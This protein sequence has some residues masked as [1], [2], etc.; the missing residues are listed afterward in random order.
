MF[1]ECS[2]FSMGNVNKLKYQMIILFC[3]MQEISILVPET[4]GLN[5]VH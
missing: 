5:F 4:G 1:A 3:I 2:N